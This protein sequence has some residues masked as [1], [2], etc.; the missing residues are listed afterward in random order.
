[1]KWTLPDGRLVELSRG[2][3]RG[4][5]AE[6]VLRV[7]DGTFVE[8]EDSAILNGVT[9]EWIR[10]VVPDGEALS[11]DLVAAILAEVRGGGG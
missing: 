4:K 8:A 5:A 3:G 11:S 6:V 9:K 10:A 1:M 7:W 2:T